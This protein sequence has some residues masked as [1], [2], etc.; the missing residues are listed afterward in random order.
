MRIVLVTAFPEDPGKPRGGVEAV[1]VTLVRQLSAFEDLDVHV[2]T[3]RPDGS[4]GSVTWNGAT[5]HTL[6]RRGRR[7]LTGAI[8]ADRR[9]VQRL[10]GTLAP[11]VVHAHDTFGLMVKGLPMPRVL[12]IHGF[13]HSDTRIAGARLARLRS[14]AWRLVE[15][16]A[17][18][19]Y[20]HI[21][22]I[23]PYVRER[24]AGIATGTIHDI[25]NPIDARFFAIPR[26]DQSPT[27]FSAAVVSRRKNTLGLVEAFGRV[28][29]SGIDAALRLAGPI[30]EPAYRQQ[31]VDRIEGLGLAPHVTWLGAIA[32]AEVAAELSRASVFALVSREE[33][34]PLGVEEAMAAGVPVVTSNRCGMPYMVR[35]GTTGYLVDPEDPDDIAARLGEL[36]RDPAHARRMG[37]RGRAVAR[38]RFHP[39]EVARRTRAVYARAAG[40][41]LS[42]PVVR[43]QAPDAASVALPAALPVRD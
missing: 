4:A 28:R 18:A 15:T 5:I 41:A 37:E 8:G 24:L 20:P 11:A 32:S 31:V 43:A 35:D 34:S 33:N 21:I 36:L 16:R 22:A 23:S 27:V 26:Q 6:R 30:V 17:W 29:R 9:Q 40:R 12:T 13:I 39:D 38:E 3:V 10:L 42:E 1:S 19:D 14:A 7:M 25:D 2:V